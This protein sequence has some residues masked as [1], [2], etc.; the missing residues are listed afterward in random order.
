[1]HI[2]LSICINMR[3]SLDD[4]ILTFFFNDT[5]TTEIYTLHIVGSVRCVQETVISAISLTDLSDARFQS[6]TQFFVLVANQICPIDGIMLKAVY[7]IN[8]F[9]LISLYLKQM[10]SQTCLLYTSPSPRDQA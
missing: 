1:M 10:Q 8:H 2:T 4:I 9:L 6:P 7:Q 3:N 5:G